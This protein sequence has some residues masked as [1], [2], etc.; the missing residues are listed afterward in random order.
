MHAAPNL[1]DCSKQI[2]HPKVEMDLIWSL[3]SVRHY[4]W[5]SDIGSSLP[6]Q[7]SVQ[8]EGTPVTRENPKEGATVWCRYGRRPG[9]VWLFVVVTAV[10]SLNPEQLKSEES[11][12]TQPTSV[13]PLQWQNQGLRKLPDL[14]QCL[15]MESALSASFLC[16]LSSNTFPAPTHKK[17][18]TPTP[19][20]VSGKVMWRTWS[21]DQK[22]WVQRIHLGHLTSQGFRSFIS[23][24]IQIHTLQCF[25][26]DWMKPSHKST[27][28]TTEEH[29]M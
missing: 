6:A 12:K 22:T 25:Y 9:R 8:N 17:S 3:Q 10:A 21:C 28:R 2:S 24:I 14:P 16:P 26:K 18:P 20:S 23:K 13:L 29:E 27:F 19:S 7:W 1:L 11:P 15:K 4:V 5:N